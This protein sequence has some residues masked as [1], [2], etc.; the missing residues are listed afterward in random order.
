MLTA[1]AIFALTTDPARPLTSNEHNKALRL[2]IEQRITTRMGTG[3]LVHFE[4]VLLDLLERIN[5][6]GAE[7]QRDLQ[8]IQRDATNAL[9]RLACGRIYSDDV[10]SLPVARVSYLADRVQRLIEEAFAAAKALAKYSDQLQ[11][12]AEQRAATIAGVAEQREKR[13]ASRTA[14]LQKRPAD[15][16][17]RDAG[18]LGLGL[19][20]NA[21]A[22]RQDLAL[23]I[24]RA[25]E[26][27]AQNLATARAE[28]AKVGGQ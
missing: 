7:L 25:E 22:T 8:R 19:A 4:E 9:A 1:A 21:R 10:S 14:T 13:I 23:A 6:A 3:D 16:L 5:D 28:E 17:R 11:A 15:E 18:A 2:V 20:N 12:T 26:A 24:A 27:K